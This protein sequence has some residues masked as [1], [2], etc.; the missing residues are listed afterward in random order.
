MRNRQMIAGWILANSH[1]I[2]ARE[3]DGKHFYVVTDAEAW[4]EAA[5]RLLALVQRIKSTGDREGAKKLFDD[6]GVHFDPALRDEVVRRYETLGVPSYS[7]FVMPRLSPVWGPD[8]AL[9]DVTISYPESLATQMLEWSGRRLP[10]VALPAD[11]AALYHDVLQ[12][13]LAAPEVELGFHI[14]TSGANTGTKDGTLRLREGNVLELRAEGPFNGTAQPIAVASDGAQFSGTAAGATLAGPVPAALHDG[15][16]QA[17][18][19]RGLMHNLAMLS[20]GHPID[21]ADGTPAG[22]AAT[23]F[24]SLPDGQIDGRATRRIAFTIQDAGQAVGETTLDVSES[25]GLPLRREQV[26]HFPQGDMTVVESYALRRPVGGA[27]M[28]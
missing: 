6:Y 17:L 12:R 21:V 8:G 18:M 16:L 24:R 20:M 10:P 4:R 3:R 23:G 14:E 11:P 22:A 7:G 27:S 15:V 2:E 13:L 9:A 19:V 5:G 1:A 25:T 26:V 28:N